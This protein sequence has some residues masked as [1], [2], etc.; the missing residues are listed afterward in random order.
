MLTCLAVFNSYPCRAGNGS[1]TAGSQELSS[2][3][4]KIPP[5][6]FIMG[7]PVGEPHRDVF[8]DDETQ[9]VVTISKEFEMQATP[10]TQDQWYLI[11]GYNY[12]YC[13]KIE[14]CKNE[15]LDINGVQICHNYPVEMI[16]WDDAKN[17]IEKLNQKQ[18]QYSYRLPTE[19]EWEYAARAGS[20][21]TYYSGKYESKLSLYAWTTENSNDQSHRVGTKIPNAF[22]LYDMEGNVWEWVNDFY[23][24]YP[25]GHVI[26]PHGAVSHPYQHR[27]YRG[28]SFF[29]P[30]WTLRSALRATDSQ[31][32]ELIDRGFRLVRTR[33]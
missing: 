6:T 20:N 10:V 2:L 29:W 27:I 33:K 9:H 25:K 3:F 26:D 4:V 16:S 13:R 8:G 22:G 5:G 18:K 24:P 28:G 15:H 1:A 21:T 17:F 31:D 19:A 11:M 7:S 32:L 12:S 14:F 23:G 30:Q